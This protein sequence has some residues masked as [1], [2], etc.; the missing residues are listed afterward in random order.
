MP[1]WSDEIYTVQ[2][3]SKGTD[4]ASLTHL[5]YET[6]FE[7]QAMYQ[8]RDP[9]NTL[10]NYKNG[11]Y[12]RSELLLVKKGSYLIRAPCTHKVECK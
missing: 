11:M 2:S 8:L 12:A 10:N 5:L 7:R 4:N 3:V 6:I 9:N 1:D